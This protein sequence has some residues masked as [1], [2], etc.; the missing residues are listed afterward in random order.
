[1]R[2]LVLTIPPIDCLEQHGE[3]GPTAKEILCAAELELCTVR[4]SLPATLFP[5]LLT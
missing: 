1:M 2:L 5:S 4:R 3:L